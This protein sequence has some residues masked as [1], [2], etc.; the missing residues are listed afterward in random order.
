MR[1]PTI[2]YVRPAKAQTSLRILSVKLL[3]EQCLEFLSL[4][5][6]CTDLSESILV[7]KPHSW[8]SPVMALMTEITVFQCSSQGGHIRANQKYLNF[9]IIRS[10]ITFFLNVDVT[11][12]SACWINLHAFFCCQIFFPKNNS[13]QKVWNQIRPDTLSSLIWVQTGCKGDLFV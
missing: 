8:K 10:V 4:K 12:D 11:N 13:H 9:H 6:G 7:K 3:T 5:G 1:F 2:W